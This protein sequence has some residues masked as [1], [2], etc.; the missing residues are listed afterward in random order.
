[1]RR[2][3]R[4]RVSG[5]PRGEAPRVNGGGAGSCTR[6]R[7]YIPAGIYDAYPLLKCRSRREEA[8]RTAGSQP[9]KIAPLPSGTTGNSQPAELTSVPH[10]QADEGGRSQVIRLR[11]RAAYPQL[12]CFPSFYEVDGPR[13][14]SYGTVLPSN[15]VRPLGRTTITHCTAFQISRQVTVRYEFTVLTWLIRTPIMR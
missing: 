9:Q 11:E 5:S 8:A 3:A 1:M 14:A 4:E 6:V 10:P 13:H 12:G 2:L 15:L 7:K